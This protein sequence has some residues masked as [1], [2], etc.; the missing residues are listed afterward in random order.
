MANETLTPEQVKALTD[1]A[2]QSGEAYGDLLNKIKKAASDTNTSITG[3]F[4]N[5][6]K[7]V[8]SGEST[9]AVALNKMGK[10]VIG[11]AASAIT[12]FGGIEKYISDYVAGM[13]KSDVATQSAK[14][15]LLLFSA[16]ALNAK[17]SFTTGTEGAIT[18][19]SQ[20]HELEQSLGAGGERATFASNALK[21]MATSL[22]IKAPAD[23]L[24]G[25]LK[26]MAIH[27]DNATRMQAG[28]V[29]FSGATG[30]LGKMYEKTGAG[31]QNMNS[32]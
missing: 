32:V 30:D 6:N 17:A 12:S 24:I 4:T 5:L 8:Q 20:I 11:F 13:G 31:L 25:V 9:F 19:T 3:V 27:A 10:S 2:A 14:N 29:A 21:T 1:A 26:N 23:Q 16:A 22:G 15:G 7:S 18:L 28:I